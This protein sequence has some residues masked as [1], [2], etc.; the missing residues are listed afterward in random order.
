MRMRR[1]IILPMLVL[2]GSCLYVGT[3][4]YLIIIDEFQDM[5]VLESRGKEFVFPPSTLNNDRRKALANIELTGNFANQRELVR[6]VDGPDVIPERTASQ[7]SNRS[8]QVHQR[9]KARR[10]LPIKLIERKASFRVKTNLPSAS[11]SEKK[12]NIEELIHYVS[13]DKYFPVDSV[14]PYLGLSKESYIQF[15][16]STVRNKHCVQRQP[17]LDECQ[18]AGGEYKIE[19]LPITRCKEQ[20][21][22]NL[23]TISDKWRSDRSVKVKVRCDV[24][25][26]GRNP[27][28]AMNLNPNTGQLEDEHLWH[29]FVS[30]ADIEANLSSVVIQ[31]SK[32]GI[33]F[34]IVQCFKNNTSQVIRTILSFPPVLA[35]TNSK[36]HK[37]RPAV[38]NMNMVVLS[39]T[40]RPHFY[41][42]LPESVATLRNIVY[43]NSKTASALDFELLQSL[44]S[45]S[46]QNLQALLSGKT[47][48]E[49]RVQGPTLFSTLK[50]LGYQNIFQTDQCWFGVDY[51]NL[52]KSFNMEWNHCDAGMTHVACQATEVY[53]VSDKLDGNHT[54][55]ASCLNGRYVFDYIFDFIDKFQLALRVTKTKSPV[56]SYTYLTLTKD[57][58]GVSIR[59]LDKR[60]SMFL[61]TMAHE[62]NT[63]TIVTSDQGPTATKYSMDTI[64]GRYEMYDPLLFMI[65]PKQISLKL[66]KQ[67]MET[68]IQNQHRL[69][70]HIDLHNTIVSIGNLGG[71][72]RGHSKGLL[73]EIAINRTCADIGI[74]EEALCKCRGWE[75]WFP[76]DDPRFT[77]IAE[78]ALGELNNILQDVMQNFY[79][80]NKAHIKCQRLIGYAIEKIHQRKDKR[81][82]S[83]DLVTHPGRKLF[84]TNIYLP[85]SFSL[86]AGNTNSLFQGSGELVKVLGFRRGDL[87]LD[88][89]PTAKSGPAINLC[90]KGFHF[91]NNMTRTKRYSGATDVKYDGNM[92]QMAHRSKHFGTH[93]RIRVLDWREKC[94]FLLTRTH[95]N[96][97]VA[98]EVLNTCVDRTFLVKVDISNQKEH[99]HLTKKLPVLVQLAPGTFRFLFCA[100]M[101]D[102]TIIL[103]P[104][105][106]FKVVKVNV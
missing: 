59:Q 66:G 97:T 15:K 91:S 54:T 87:Q 95:F 67:Q 8:E 31:N 52:G 25:R 83:L 38:L 40:S 71:N 103:Q 51:K 56:F 42:S 104:K 73:A 81:V 69:I 55:S 1:A 84:E 39:S 14:C 100:Y 46:A 47:Y 18:K 79:L 63:L 77:W 33:N 24:R 37:P 76:D 22:K 62:E 34:C 105:I 16:D 4:L 94:L 60:L 3:F 82:L 28:Y 29:K 64:S 41:R 85:I 101:R 96:Q 93:S 5:V 43:D 99:V 13:N 57:E 106:S 58:L 80:L 23:C 48:G 19:S 12:R 26:C 75:E 21:E 2:F 32:N 50:K 44:T 27:I 102:K 78:F 90:L 30:K 36:H 7:R 98:L 92:L 86:E 88:L 17:S 20:T 70:S 11:E 10:E 35:G 61:Q 68:L 49:T 6:N 9:K 65:I 89:T 45:D 74:S 53:R 72:Q